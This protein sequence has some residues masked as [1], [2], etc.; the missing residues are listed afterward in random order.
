MEIDQ[1]AEEDQRADDGELVR[2]GHPLDR[3]RPDIE[4]RGQGGQRDVHQADL[5]A[6]EHGREQDQCEDRARRGRN[7]PVAPSACR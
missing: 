1:P 6:G 4:G 2:K 7:D 3:A 5:Q